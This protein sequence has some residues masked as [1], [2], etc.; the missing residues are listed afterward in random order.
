MAVVVVAS[1]VVL[2][3]GV[4]VCS[5]DVVGIVVVAS[6]GILVVIGVVGS[7]KW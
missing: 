5:V 6:V 1:V 2:K 7:V 4:V 3:V